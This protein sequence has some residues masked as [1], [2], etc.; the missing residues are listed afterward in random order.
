[1]QPNHALMAL[2]I[3]HLKLFVVLSFISWNAFSV[4]SSQAAPGKQPQ[5]QS[6]AIS[7]LYVAESSLV[8]AAWGFRLSDGAPLRPGFSPKKPCPKGAKADLAPVTKR[9]SSN[10]DYPFAA[11]YDYSKDKH[12][13]EQAAQT[14]KQFELLIAAAS[15]EEGVHSRTAAKLKWHLASLYHYSGDGDF[16][17]LQSEAKR[18]LFPNCPHC[19]KNDAV[20]MLSPAPNVSIEDQLQNGWWICNKC[21]SGGGQ[22]FRAA[23]STSYG[24]PAGLDHY[25]SHELSKMIVLAPSVGLFFF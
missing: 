6:A 1:M 25:G 20:A 9:S 21:E 19:H 2:M 14:E 18:I 11:D 22:P 17:R 15:S 3:I 8:E 5:R 23:R 7:K 12:W 16:N 10:C 4:P 24:F 13:R